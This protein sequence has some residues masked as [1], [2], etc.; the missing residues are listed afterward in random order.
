ML[1]LGRAGALAQP[2]PGRQT[3]RVPRSRS[4][5]PASVTRSY[6]GYRSLRGPLQPTLG[7]IDVVA[8]QNAEYA[9]RFVELGIPSHRV[10]VTG[11]VKYDGLESDRN[12]A[13]TRE[14][15]QLLGLASTDLVFV[16]GSTMEGEEAAVLAA[17][18]AARRQHPGLAADPGSPP[19]GAIRRAWR[20]W[21]DQ[22]K[23]R[24][25]C[26]EAELTTPVPRTPRRLASDHP[27]RHDRRAW[28]R[29]GVWPTWLSW[30]EACGP[31]AAART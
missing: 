22:S 18:N 8:A 29:S 31:A 5:T 11:S 7:R 2:D 25:S 13:K 19:R 27:D 1:A 20:S 23:A 16:A 24:R 12:N 30:G 26:A 28:R 6:R 9:R 10:S 15:R 14:L 17:Y 4:S 3:I 21:L